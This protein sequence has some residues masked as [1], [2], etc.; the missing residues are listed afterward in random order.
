M[1]VCGSLYMCALVC[2]FVAHA[3]CFSDQQW[4]IFRFVAF[5]VSCGTAAFVLLDGGR[6]EQQQLNG[7]HD[8]TDAECF[9]SIELHCAA[10]YVVGTLGA[11]RN[12]ISNFE[13]GAFP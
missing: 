8:I 10:L 12:S 11:W 2:S 3:T 7:E 5:S 6:G 13:V 1:Y 4:V 9:D